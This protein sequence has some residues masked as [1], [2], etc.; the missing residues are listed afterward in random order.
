M[1]TSFENGVA[2][3]RLQKLQ[4]KKNCYVLCHQHHYFMPK[5]VQI[6]RMCIRN[7]YENWVRSLRFRFLSFMSSKVHIMLLKLSQLTEHA[8][9]MHQRSVHASRW[10]ELCSLTLPFSPLPSSPHC[11]LDPAR[12]KLELS[13]ELPDWLTNVPYSNTSPWLLS[14]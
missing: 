8:L 13:H 2:R 12:M 3:R 4:G 9:M 10:W 1:F 7:K 14:H 5:F 6:L 11:F